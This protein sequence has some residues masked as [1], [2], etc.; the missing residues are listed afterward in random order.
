MDKKPNILVFDIETAPITAYVWDLFD[1][2][3]GLNQIKTDSHLL[4]WA[5]K[6]LGGPV[7]QVMYM[8]NRRA[9]DITNDK[10]LVKGLARLLNKADIVVTQNGKAFDT[11]RFNARAIINGLPPMKP[12]LHT[13]ILKESRKV[14]KFTSHKLA[15][16]TEKLNT[17]Y[18]KLEHNKFPGFDLWASIL[19]GDIKAWDEMKRYNIHDVLATE[20][21]Y[22]K[23]QGWIKTQNLG[24]YASDVTTRCWCG[25]SNLSPRGYARTD[26]GKYRQYVCNAC[27]KWPRGKQNLL[28]FE[29][30][31]SLLKHWR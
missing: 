27:G 23:I 30:R 10:A 3:V 9:K 21:A 26:G 25:S 2:N 20:E 31:K 14:F 11:K 18:K 29:K 4:S 24:A 1:Q 15:Y 16:I 5:A 19:T 22:Q 6:W 13:D 28:S 8:D 7:S 12:Y 17:R